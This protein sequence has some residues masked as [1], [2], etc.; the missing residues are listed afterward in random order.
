MAEMPA[1]QAEAFKLVHIS[2]LSPAVAARI[3]DVSPATV[4]SNLRH[5]RTRLRELLHE[6]R[7]EMS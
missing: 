5:A 2:G 6:A 4:R 1:R 3:M 7:D